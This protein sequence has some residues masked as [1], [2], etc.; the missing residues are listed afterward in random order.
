MGLAMHGFHDVYK[1]FPPGFDGEKWGWGVYLLPYLEEQPLHDALPLANPLAVIPLTEQALP[2]FLCPADPQSA[3]INPWFTGYAKSNY[4]IS[5]QVS[6]GNSQIPI[7]WITDGTSNTIM[8]GERDAFTQIGA[9]WPGR[10]TVPSG[11]SVA[12]VMGRPNWP[13][14]TPYAGGTDLLRQRSQRHP[15]RL[16]KLSHRR[17]QLRLRR[18]L[19]PLPAP[20]PGE[21]SQSRKRQQ[22]RG[23]QLPAA[24]P[25][26]PRRRQPHR[27]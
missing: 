15:L 9:L 27:I 3:T 19:G 20:V 17:R 22:A 5:E 13:I 16:V 4:A 21:R 6:D 26:L 1:Y 11:V 2:V 23:R 24:K 8:I 7:A 14:N 18:R 12:S 25:L 10:D